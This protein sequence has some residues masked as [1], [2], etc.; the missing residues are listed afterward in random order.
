MPKR[1]LGYSTLP[2]SK[3]PVSFLLLLLLAIGLSACAELQRHP[4]LEESLNVPLKVS[5]GQKIWRETIKRDLPNAFGKADVLGR[6]VDAGYRELRFLGLEGESTVLLGYREQEI[7]SNETTMSR[8][9]VGFVNLHSYGGTT[10]GTI[11]GPPSS[12]T[13][14]LGPLEV[15]IKHDVSRDANFVHSGI[16]LHIEKADRHEL[17]YSLSRE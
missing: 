5:V 12:T 2:S 11:V 3:T 15:L 14:A 9:G 7:Y 10:T 4:S 6:T 17:V 1:P 16:R 13:Q 8:S